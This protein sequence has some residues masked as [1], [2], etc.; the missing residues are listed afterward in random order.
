MIV[1]RLCLWGEDI[2]LRVS[3]SQRAKRAKRDSHY[4]HVRLN[5]MAQND[6]MGVSKDSARVT[7]EVHILAHFEVAHCRA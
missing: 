1:Y 4:R 6:W 7:K 3:D 5:R 2:S